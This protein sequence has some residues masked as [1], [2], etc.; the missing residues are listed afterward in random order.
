MGKEMNDN[1]ELPLCPK[2]GDTKHVISEWGIRNK[3]SC[4][5]C[6]IEWTRNYI[7]DLETG[8]KH[9]FGGEMT[10]RFVREH[11]MKWWDSP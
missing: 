3:H 7:W 4:E 6:Q 9:V 5:E 1:L 2:C 8:E 11:P 10:H